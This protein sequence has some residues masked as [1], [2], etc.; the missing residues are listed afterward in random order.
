MGNFGY[1]ESFNSS[2]TSRT[3]WFLAM[4]S[5]LYYCKECTNWICAIE[6]LIKFGHEF[7]IS[8]VSQENIN[9]VI[10][11][12]I[13]LFKLRRWHKSSKTP[14][15][16]NINDVKCQIT[17]KMCSACYISMKSEIFKKVIRV[18]LG[19]Q[20]QISAKSLFLFHRQ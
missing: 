20:Y 19:T 12:I 18:H 13:I 14:I 7:I 6:G 10:S 5:K 9:W 16:K 3:L 8:L 15:W 17:E 11:I 2:K 1:R 4:Q